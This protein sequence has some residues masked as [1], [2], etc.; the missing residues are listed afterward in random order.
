MQAIFGRIGICVAVGRAG[1]RGRVAAAA[2]LLLI[3]LLFASSAPKAEAAEASKAVLKS[4]GTPNGEEGGRLVFAKGVAVYQATGDVYVAEANTNHRISQFDEEGNFIRT[5]GF[6]VIASGKPGD[7]GTGFEICNAVPGPTPGENCKKGV[8]GAAAGQLANPQ[9]IAIDQSNG[10]LYVTSITNRRVDVFT[11][12]GQFAGAFGYDVL[13]ADPNPSGPDFCTAVT[14]CQIAAAAGAQAGRFS[15]LNGA[16]PAVDPNVPGRVY[17]PDNGNLRVAQYSTTVSAGVL[18]SV[19]FERAFGWGVDTGAAQLESCTL[20]SE[21]QVGTSGNGSGQFTTGGSPTAVGVDGDGFIYVTSGPLTSGTCSAATPCRIQKFA[22]DASSATNFGPSSAP[23]QLTFAS[24]EAANQVAALNLAIDPSD[25]HVYVLRKGKNLGGETP[26]ATEYQVHEYDSSGTYQ[27]THPL[28][29]ALP[30]FT[31]TQST[32][33]AVGTGG[34]IYASYGAGA[35]SVSQ[36]F[37]LGPVPAPGVKL[38]PPVENIT[39]TSATVNGVVTIQPPGGAGFE[40]SYRFELKRSG[41]PW[42]IVKEGVTGSVAGDYPVSVD[43]VDLDPN[44][45]YLVRLGATTSADV[46]TPPLDFE[47][48]QEGPRVSLTYVEEV[49]QD[50]AVLSAHIDPRGLNSSYHFEWASEEEWEATGKYTHQVPAKDRQI[51]SGNKAVIVQEPITGL[52]PGT[53]YRFRV[54]ATNASGVTDGSGEYFETLNACGLTDSRCF[55]LVSPADKGPVGAAGDTIGNGQELRFQADPL[56]P[57]IAYEM[58]YALPDSASG[59]EAMFQA[60]RSAAGWASSELTAPTLVAG[61]PSS[62]PSI[63]LGL[64]KD[65]SCGFFSS[66]QPLAADAPSAAVEAGVANLFRRERSGEW[67]TVTTMAPTNQVIAPMQGQYQ[68]VGIS[69]EPSGEQCGRMYFR[70][71]MVYPGGAGDGAG[72]FRLYEWDGEMLHNVGLIPGESGPEAVGAVPGAAA[73]PDSPAPA[74]AE[75]APNYR[76]AVSDDGSRIYFT[77]ISKV[78]GDKGQQ[79]IFLRDDGE[80]AIDVSQ[81]QAATPNNDDS[82]YLGASDDGG[83]VFF[84]ARYGLTAQVSGDLETCSSGQEEKPNGPGCDLYRYS[85]GTGTLTDLS[86]DGGFN[87]KGASVAGILGV[88]EDG[89]HVYFAARGQLDGQGA[90]ESENVAAA[91]YNVY[92]S[93]NGDLTYVGKLSQ[94][95]ADRALTNKTSASVSSPTW[96]SRVSEDGRFLLFESRAGIASYDSGGRAEAYLF[97]ATTDQVR[98]VSCRRDGEPSL[99]PVN[100]ELLANGTNDSNNKLNPASS[101]AVSSDGRARVFFKSLNRLASGAIEGKQNLYQ[102]E[103][104]QISFLS[105][106]DKGSAQDLQFAGASAS[107]DDVYLTTLDRL[108]WGDTDG[109]LDLYDARVGGGIPQPPGPPVPC[110]PLSEGS[111]QDGSGSTGNPPTPPSA[112]FNGPGNE[113][114]P[115]EDERCTKLAQNARAAS[116]KSKRLFAAAKEATGKKA[117]KL[118]KRAEQASQS[119]KRASQ[120]AK[121]CREASR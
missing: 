64:A 69:E 62:I 31:A 7:T 102:W 70:A 43:L 23:G 60:N 109:Q 114:P 57:G 101:L 10:M 92:L 98:C 9:G 107:G 18:T 20:V 41:E 24:G 73:N 87:D 30:A 74:D 79:A 26:S 115:P 119:A 40:A 53:G 52:Q 90:T 19:T 63:T 44:T 104:G 86:A 35:P 37:I 5:W 58:A 65:L 83:Q 14:G 2:I 120:S 94:Q 111:C 42:Q 33:I 106:S 29:N 54:V 1:D 45:L 66:Y 4:F 100:Y 22:P 95:G 6:D 84:A 77:A 71:P 48:A 91:T 68:L 82:R 103:E 105:S 13:P 17:V 67:T 118:K 88:D 56:K 46:V 49:T 39:G 36:V 16:T 99:T 11:S 96:S 32:G 50:A 117:R 8:T 27:A 78:G 121:T 47:T 61:L 113:A 21:C 75:E 93:A 59:G 38:V 116:A 25:D 3:L 112:V 34:L 28:G 55:E 51:G 108:T 76:D 85:V 81:S 72:V 89:S 15:N 12:T 80:V 97:D 110:N